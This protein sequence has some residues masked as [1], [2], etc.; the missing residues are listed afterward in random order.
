MS[1]EQSAE[2][3]AA[4]TIAALDERRIEPEASAG[5]VQETDF[6]VEQ[7]A[8]SLMDFYIRAVE[9]CCPVPTAYAEARL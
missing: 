7:S 6:C 5:A 1:L 9:P 3:W 8:S 4:K 2:K